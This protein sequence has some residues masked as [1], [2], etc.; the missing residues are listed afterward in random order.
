MARPEKVA[1]VESISE[2]FEKARSVV[3]NDFTGLDVEKISQLR[4]LCRENNVEYRVV[5]NTLAKRAVKDTDAAALDGYL[6]GP[7]ALAISQTSENEAAKV[8][9]DFADENELPKV[10]AGFVDG[11][12]IDATAVLALS[13]LPSKNEMLSQVLAGIKSPA[14]GLVAVM[15]GPL[16]NLLNVLNQIK[17]Q[18]E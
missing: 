18:K 10:K 14:G 15:Q 5:K 13:K 2:V 7:T 4:R 9:A 16:R 11:N 3:L 12:V 17:E 8:L 6:D 1:A